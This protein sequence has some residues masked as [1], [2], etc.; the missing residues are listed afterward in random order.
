[1]TG[2]A[3]DRIVKYNSM[4]KITTLAAFIISDPSW[5]NTL[6]AGAQQGLICMPALVECVCETDK[7]NGLFWWDKACVSGATRN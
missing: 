2:A 5:P 4:V 7:Y 6:V 1:M 3:F